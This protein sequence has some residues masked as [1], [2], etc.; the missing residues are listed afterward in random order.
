VLLAASTKG[1]PNFIPPVVTGVVGKKCTVITEISGKTYDADP[2]ILF[3][4]VSKCELIKDYALEETS[5]SYSNLAVHTMTDEPAKAIANEQVETEETKSPQ[6]T[7]PK[8]VVDPTDPDT[9]EV[10]TDLHDLSVQIY[11]DML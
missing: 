7:P 2:R 11:F 4:T 1:C 3:F 5:S 9:D 8:D 6:A 10:L